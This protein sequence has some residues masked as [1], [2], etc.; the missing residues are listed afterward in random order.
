MIQRG[1]TQLEAQDHGG[2]GR[3]G[4]G[5]P[6]RAQ[7]DHV[8]WHP[9]G[10][11]SRQTSPPEGRAAA[12]DQDRPAAAAPP[13]ATTLSARSAFGRSSTETRPNIAKPVRNAGW[14]VAVV[15]RAAWLCVVRI[16]GLWSTG[17][18]PP[19]S[20]Y[21]HDRVDANSLKIVEK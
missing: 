3:R 11:R 13:N 18:D 12:Q 16:A 1:E 9:R 2:G 4:H 15:T 17:T 7:L 8:A 10:R 19:T 20:A 21:G 14:L 6:R 5:Q